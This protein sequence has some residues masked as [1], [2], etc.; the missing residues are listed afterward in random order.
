MSVAMK[1][2]AFV[3]AMFA[4][5]GVIVVRVAM[6]GLRKRSPRLQWFRNAIVGSSKQAVVAALGPPPTTLGNDGT[7]YYPLDRRARL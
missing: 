6:H 4:F 1:P 3:Y 2:Q 7:W 5:V